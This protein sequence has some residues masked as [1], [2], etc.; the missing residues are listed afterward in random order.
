W[1]QPD[2]RTSW[3]VNRGF[4]GHEHLDAFG[5]INMNG[6]VYDPL[7]SMFMS[8]DP[9]VQAPGN[10][11][12]YN[13]YG[14]CLN[15][16]LIYTDPSG[17]IAWFVPVIIGAVIGAYS[18][19]VIANDGQYNPTKWDYS[20]GKTWGYMLG[21]AV[22]GAGSAYLGIG[23]AAGGGFMANTMGIMTASYMNSMGMTALSGGMIQPSIS[24]GV[25]SYNFGTGEWGYLGKKGNK[26][27][28]NVGY[29]F[30]ALVNLTD[31]VSLFGGG[32]NVDLIV[33]KKDAVSHSALV[34]ESEG[35]NISVGP[36]SEL[37]EGIDMEALKSGT[38]TLKEL[39]RTMK[40]KIWE[41]HA[42]DGNGWKVSINNV[43][44]NILQK[45]SN[46]LQTKM[47][48][49]TLMWNLLGK[50]CV[51][52]TSKALWSVGVPNLGG[53][54]PYWLQLQMITRQVGIYSSPY[55]YQIP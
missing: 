32:T 22:V 26:W 27:Y 13:R 45:L 25:A 8:P 48:N 15:N 29:G 53:I 43:N 52:Y 51:G 1:T 3:I 34:N 41:N 17:E 40:G 38:G 24:F 28:E 9:Y 39:S 4:T 7:T 12:N 35:I 42:T 31:V 37:G 10:W 30:G 49:Q 50:S 55:L 19:G 5:I 2:T 44:K 23:V 6:W 33:E 20:S 21:G 16:P 18:G 36:N 14:Y 54:H 11:L 46:S 47:D